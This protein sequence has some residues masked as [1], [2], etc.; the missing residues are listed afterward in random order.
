MSSQPL[1]QAGIIISAVIL[2][3][4]FTGFI[5]SLRKPATPA[6]V[7][8]T[9]RIGDI[10]NLVLAS[11]Q[12]DAVRRVNVGAQVS[13]L[14]KSVNVKQGDVVV[15]GQLIATIDDVQ[16][17][18]E[19]RNAEAALDE[20]KASLKAKQA[21]FKKER[22]HYRRQKKMLREKASSDQ[23]FEAAEAT[24]A[25]AHAD[26]LSLN[27]SLI[28]AEIEVDNKKVNIGYT[29]VVAPMDGTV[30]AVVTLQGQ[31][32]NSSQSAPTII[33][34]AQLDVM[35]VRA[36][37]SEADI[38]RITCGQKANFTVF[39]EPDRHYAATLRTI[40]L[41]PESFIKDESS[42]SGTSSPGT[43]NQASAVYYDALLDLPNSDN[44]LRIG[45]H[46]QV[47]LIISEGTH[48]LLIPA[49][50]VHTINNNKHQVQILTANQKVETRDVKI[51]ISNSEDVQILEGLTAGEI[52]LLSQPDEPVFG[53]VMAA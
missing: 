36:K 17:R 26:L 4:F 35:T 43:G 16:Q 12:I 53:D 5:L 46:A 25:S 42:L 33:K 19:L 8:A 2:F 23:E 32:V 39:S 47:S 30:I 22:L 34:M 40:E 41:A 45:M 28:K 29:R 52:V 13:G 3:L 49:Q 51:G 20:V 37:I 11:G 31:T 24:L 38:T 9:V 10:E 1:K 7:T 44:R 50:A 14:V 18:N 21:Q 48:T 27:A 15:K 6:Y